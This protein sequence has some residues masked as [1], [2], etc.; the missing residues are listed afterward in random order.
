MAFWQAAFA[1]AAAKVLS[2]RSFVGAASSSGPVEAGSS[3]V[4]G[5]GTSRV[6]GV[7][8]S[9]VGELT[10]AKKAVVGSTSVL[11]PGVAKP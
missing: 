3:L 11:D 7:E 6:D 5:V 10:D 2:A 4:D 9:T 8:A 1:D